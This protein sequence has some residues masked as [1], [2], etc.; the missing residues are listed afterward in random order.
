MKTRI[1]APLALILGTASIAGAQAPRATPAP[2]APG[3]VL[4]IIAFG[5]TRTC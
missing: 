2:I 1:F 3:T 5:P 4:H